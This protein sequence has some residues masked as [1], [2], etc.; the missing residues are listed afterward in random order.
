MEVTPEVIDIGNL[1]N[2]NIVELKSN[3]SFDEEIDTVN[4]LSLIHI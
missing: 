1:D 3:A 2:D 4:I